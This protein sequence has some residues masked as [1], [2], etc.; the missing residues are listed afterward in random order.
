MAQLIP[1]KIR[2]LKATLRKAGAYQISQE[3]SHTKWKHP[4]LP[5]HIVVLSGSD[6]D[7]A[8]PYQE[9]DVRNMLED[10]KRAKEKTL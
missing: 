1:P 6:G 2:K 4:L 3:G 5:S 9:K 8:K 7:D 10:I